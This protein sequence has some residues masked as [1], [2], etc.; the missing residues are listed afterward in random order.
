MLWTQWVVVC[1]AGTGKTLLARAAA[2]ECGA[3]FLGIN[4]SSVASKWFGDGV[5]FVK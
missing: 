1:C 5:K 3:S 2:A 4:P